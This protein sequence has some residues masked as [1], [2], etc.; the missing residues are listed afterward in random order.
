V[1]E[2]LYRQSPTLAFITSSITS[3]SDGLHTQAVQVFNLLFDEFEDIFA[4]LFLR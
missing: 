3:H 1:W 4:G 2:L